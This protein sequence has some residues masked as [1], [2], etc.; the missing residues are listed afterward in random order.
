MISKKD[1][2]GFIELHYSFVAYHQ[3][4]NGY[5]G[6]LKSFIRDNMTL[7]DIRS[8]MKL[9]AFAANQL[10]GR[11]IYHLSIKYSMPWKNLD[12]VNTFRHPKEAEAILKE[13]EK[14]PGTYLEKIYK[15]VANN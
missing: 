7:E 9:G 4:V 14:H 5:K 2:L 6:D 3:K 1:V 11:E 12:W 15:W 13:I 10:R 8:M